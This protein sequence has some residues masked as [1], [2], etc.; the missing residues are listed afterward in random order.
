MGL[1]LDPWPVNFFRKDY[2]I[3]GEVKLA[4]R[5]PG[6]FN[7]TILP[8]SFEFQL[9]SKDWT[10]PLDTS[11][12]VETRHLTYWLHHNVPTV[13][14]SVSTDGQGLRRAVYGRLIDKMFYQWLVLERGMWTQDRTVKITFGDT[15]LVQ[16]LEGSQPQ[17]GSTDA[18]ASAIRAWTRPLSPQEVP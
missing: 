14:F 4:R 17:A 18:L 9:K 15:D 1:A 5:D 10:I 2:G 3:D 7:A 6:E 11:I 8:W 12:V 16:H 13:L